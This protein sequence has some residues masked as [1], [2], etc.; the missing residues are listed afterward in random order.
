MQNAPNV[1]RAISIDRVDASSSRLLRENARERDQGDRNRHSRDREGQRPPI[2]DEV[3][4]WTGGLGLA[5]GVSR[6][7]H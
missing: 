2:G 3:G 5:Y 7:P 6:L 4:E 1:F